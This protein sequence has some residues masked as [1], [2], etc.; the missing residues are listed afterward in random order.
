[1]DGVELEEPSAELAEL[2][3]DNVARAYD[4]EDASILILD[5]KIRIRIL[6]DLGCPAAAFGDL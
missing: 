3:E 4:K 2:V 5:A 6:G 1:M